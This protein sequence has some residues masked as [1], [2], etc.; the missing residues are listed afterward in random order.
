MF[1]KR[2]MTTMPRAAIVGAAAAL[3]LIIA[4]CGATAP[5]EH[6]TGGKATPQPSP[7]AKSTPTPTP[8]PSL[9]LAEASSP[10]FRAQFPLVPC[11]TLPATLRTEWESLLVGSSVGKCPV[12]DFISKYVPQNVPVTNYDKAMSQAQAN[13]YGQAF[14]DTLAWSTMSAY[15]DAPNLL[16]KVGLG[17]GPNQPVLNWEQDGARVTSPDPGQDTYPDKIVII[18]L[19]PAQANNIM[20]N[21]KATFAIA[22]GYN[23]TPYSMTWSAPGQSFSN[24]VDPPGLDTGTLATNP[25]LGTYF[26]V[27]TYINDCAIGTGVGLCQY[28]GVS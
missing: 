21:D 8:A 9:T 24:Y 26:Y 16:L 12:P 25:A 6:P 28:A 22:I 17:L 10:N 15:A 19:T 7:T 18:P 13:A 2:T 14:I 3:A 5:T 27:D 4:G 23:Q 20:L 11:S 1:T